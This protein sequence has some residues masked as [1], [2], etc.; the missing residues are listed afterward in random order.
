LARS[1]PNP[2]TPTNEGGGGSTDT[3]FFTGYA[4]LPTGI[5]ASEMYKVV[6]IG[7][8]VRCDTGEI[9]SADCTLATEVGKHFFAKLVKGR[10]LDEDFRILVNEV[11]R[12]YHGS[13]QK[14]IVTALKIARE[15]YRA[16]LEASLG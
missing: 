15:K 3:L 9:M 1:D 5:T 10:R 12:R 14:A 6:G 2:E 4:R 13:A 11:E 8:E 16:H 7:L